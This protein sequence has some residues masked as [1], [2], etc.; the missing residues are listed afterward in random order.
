MDGGY[1]ED[2]VD[3]AGD[4]GG[5]KGADHYNCPYR[6]SDEGLFFLLEIGLRWLLWRSCQ[7]GTNRGGI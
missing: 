2:N 4:D 1:Y 6:T 5:D 3:V 7:L